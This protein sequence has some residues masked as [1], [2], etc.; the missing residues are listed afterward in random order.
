MLS[1]SKSTFVNIKENI[2][3]TRHEKIEQQYKYVKTNGHDQHMF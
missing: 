1:E 3:S 2:E